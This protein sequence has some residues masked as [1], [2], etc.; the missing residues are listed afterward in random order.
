M[1]QAARRREL[2]TTGSG[3]ST[4]SPFLPSKR[5]CS[6]LTLGLVMYR[7]NTR[8]HMLEQVP[9]MEAVA[10]IDALSIGVNGGLRTFTDMMHRLG[11]K[12]WVRRI[13]MCA[14]LSQEHVCPQRRSVLSYSLMK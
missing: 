7:V 4:S 12:F 1:D 5:L 6:F 3:S 13:W 2:T 8:V 11:V 10:R 14:F 9:F